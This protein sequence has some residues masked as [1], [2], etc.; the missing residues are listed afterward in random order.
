[1]KQTG[2]V[3]NI[4]INGVEMTFSYNFSRMPVVGEYVWINYHEDSGLYRILE[5]VH[6]P[7]VDY[8]LDA[9]AQAEPVECGLQYVDSDSHSITDILDNF[10][11]TKPAE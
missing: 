1:M 4:H 7:T 8:D 6:T 2:A 11:K 9:W 10:F 5:I 3:V